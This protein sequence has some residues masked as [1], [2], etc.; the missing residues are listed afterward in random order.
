M[1]KVG[2]VLVVGG[3]VS[4]MQAALDLADS[5]LKVYL[6][7]K[8]RYVGG[9][10]AKLDKTFPTNDCAMCTISPRLV[11]I[12][13]HENI[14]IITGADVH[15]VSGEK[16]NFTVKI[17]QKARYINN[18][19]CTG[20]SLCAEVCPVEIESDY[21]FGLDNKKAA[22]KDYPQAV[23]STFAIEK[24]TAAPCKRFC[25]FDISVQGIIAL[26]SKGQFKEAYDL[27]MNSMP[28]PNFCFDICSNPCEVKC[29][30]GA[31]DSVI[32]IKALKSFLKHLYHEK[33]EDVEIIEKMNQ[34]KKVAVIGSGSKGIFAAFKLKSEGY[35]VDVI[36]A[37]DSFMTDILSDSS[38][39]G[40]ASDLL[41]SDIDALKN[42]FKVN[43]NSSIDPA[44]L[45]TDGYDYVVVT[46][47][48]DGITGS[49][50]YKT[51]NDKIFSAIGVAEPSDKWS[52]SLQNAQDGLNVALS[53]IRNTQD[54]EVEVKR[55]AATADIDKISKPPKFN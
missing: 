6:I 14:S 44:K 55:L 38:F 29:R 23:P 28:L 4:G 13:K 51:D 50:D 16:G 45:L 12:D 22:Y 48:I 33:G 39:S 9:I 10:M 24:R 42:D 40:K 7:E 5:G 46:D 26:I 1:D 43:V 3:G 2:A 52:K 17:K 8:R 35:D 37:N 18:D 21:E 41:K 31:F 32:K 49:D 19:R 30:K 15:E 25:P 20:C 54:R 27:I 11:T 34:N 36:S 47:E 53:L